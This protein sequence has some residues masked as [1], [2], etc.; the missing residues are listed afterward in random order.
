MH[1]DG[2]K[3][4][5]ALITEHLETIPDANICLRI[6]DYRIEIVQIQDNMI[7]TAK[8]SEEPQRF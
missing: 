7:K 5:N 6:N 1:T 8:L 2:T 4:L 3:P